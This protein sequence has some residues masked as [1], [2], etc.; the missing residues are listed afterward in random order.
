MQVGAA[1][2]RAAVLIFAAIPLFGQTAAGML[3]RLDGIAWEAAPSA[4]CT[5]RI[6]VQMDIYA[7]VQW[8]HHCS[9]TRD[10]VIRETFFYVFG[11]P[12]RIALLRVDVRPADESPADYRAPAARAPT[13]AGRTLRRSHARTGN[14]GNRLS[15]P[16]LRRTRGG[17]PLEG[18]R[19]ALLP[20][21]QPERV[22]P[23]GRPPRRPTHRHQRP[24]VRGAHAGCPDPACGRHLRRGTRR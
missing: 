22:E 16:A 9:D 13:R 19:P 14:D 18:R 23:D 17:R 8:T 15:P 4:A 24:P 6:P 3:A 20:A 1:M 21:R 10:G 12:A 7:T 11:E 2:I 5:P